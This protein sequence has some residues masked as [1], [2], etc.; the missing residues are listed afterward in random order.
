MSEL[1][2]QVVFIIERQ[3]KIL[4]LLNK[5][6]VIETEPNPIR[7]KYMNICCII[8][9]KLLIFSVAKKHEAVAKS[10]AK[11]YDILGAPSELLDSPRSRWATSNISILN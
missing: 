1:H 4:L 5:E 8:F 2:K 10:N 9:F 11:A 7:R 6:N 3:N